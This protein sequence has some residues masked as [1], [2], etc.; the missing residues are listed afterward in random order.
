MPLLNEGTTV[1]RPVI[2]TE[3]GNNVYRIEGT[4]SG[5]NSEDLDEEWQFPIGSYV[6]CI[7][8]Q[9]ENNILIADALLS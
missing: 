9:D 3:M 8:K 2:A 7:N 1:L 4:E 5:L 6:T